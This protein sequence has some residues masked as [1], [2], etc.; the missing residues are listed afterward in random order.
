M[1]S[2]EEFRREH[3]DDL[4]E[5]RA[6]VPNAA[7][8]FDEITGAPKLIS[9]Q[10]GFL[11]GAAGQGRAVSGITATLFA[12]DPDQAA[13]A[14]LQEHNSLFGHGAEALDNAW[15]RRET[16]GPHNGLRT[17]VWQQ[18]AASIPIFEAVL[19]AHTTR[20]GELVNL[21][22]SFLPDPEQAAQQADLAAGRT[23][24]IP[25]IAARAAVK[26]AAEN[27][28]D[29][30]TEEQVVSVSGMNTGPELRET[31][32]A[33]G[34]LGEAAAALAWLPMNRQQLRLC[35]DVLLTSR[36]RG[37]MFRLLVDAQTGE[38]LVRHCLTDYLSDATY[39]VFT[40]DSPSPFSPGNST[41]VAAQP[42]FGS[43]VLV[44]LPALS[45]NAS[46]SGWINDNG[47]ET[48]GNNV[49]AH[50]DRNND[51]LAD[52][53]RPQGSPARTFDFAMDVSTQDPMS[54]SPAA[55]VQLFYLCNWM[56]DKLYD[57]GFTESAGNFQSNNFG[58]GGLSADAVQADAQDGGGFNNANF[59]TPPDGSPGRM[60]MYL[61]DGPAPDR[62]GDLDAEIVLHEYAHGLSNRRVGGGVGM[63]AL[64]S[65]GLGE[66]WSDFYALALL[67]ESGDDVNGC[68]ATGG[69]ATY[70]LS[71]L[72]QNYYFGIRRYPYSLDLSKNPL[73]FK[74]ID[75]AQASAHAGIPIS[76]II[77]NAAN[78]V[79]NMGEVWCV[80]LWET[81]A[82]LVNKYGWAGANAL[83]L[84]LVTDGMNLCPPNP[85][86][87]QA[88]DAILQADLV[89]SG[90]ENR[91][92]LWNGFA[93]R[94]LGQ[95]A[96]SPVSST[97]T[98]LIEA[99]DVPDTLQISPKLLA[100]SGPIGG[101]FTPNP[102][103]FI[104][105][106]WGADTLTWKL[107]NN[108]DWLAVAP[109]NGTLPAG[110]PA[111]IVTVAISGVTT[112]LSLGTSRATIWFTNQTSGIAQ[113]RVVILSV[114]GRTLFEDFEPGIHLSLWSGFGGTVGGTVIATNY[115]GSV[116]GLNS[117]WFGDADARSATTTAVNTTAGGS[118]SFYLRF[119]NGESAPWEIVELPSEGVV[120]ECSTNSG[121]SWTTLGSYGTAT[122]YNWTQV[123][124]TLPTGA[125]GL[126]TQ[127]RWRQL[128]HSGTCCD[129][130]AL[131]DIRIDAGPSS[132][133]V[134]NQP[135]SQTV[136]SGLNGSFTVSAQGSFPLIYQWRKD[137]AN[138]AN[139][140]RI[141]GAT[142]AT[143][144]ISSVLESDSGA[145]SVLV[146]NLYGSIISSNAMLLVTPLDHFEWSLISSPQA[147]GIPFSATL[148][149]KDAFNTTISN[150]SG[151]VNLSAVA[152]VAG[153]DVPLNLLPPA[154]TNFIGG[155]WSG[156]LTIQTPG[157][158]AV[159]RAED[160]NGHVG[161]S[162]IFDV[163]LQDDLSIT[164]TAS[165]D[166][167]AIGASLTYTITVANAG[168]SAATG[169]TVTNHLPAGA[170]FVSATVS[171]GTFTLTDGVVVCHLEALP[172]ATNAIVSIRVV[173]MVGGFITNNAVVSRAEAD[174]SLANNS[175][176]TV[177]FVQMPG[178][179][180]N[181]LD[182]LERNFGTTNVV[183]TVS[184]SSVP[185]LPVRLDYAT[186][187]GTAL[188]GSDYFSTNGT[189]TFLPGETNKVISVVVVGDNT[190]EPDETFLVTLTNP[191]NATLADGQGVGTILNDDVP[192]AVYLRSTVGP[193]WD[194]TVNE[195]AMN[196]VFGTNKW[197][198]LRYE[199][200][201]LAVL[202]SSGTTFIYMEGSDFNATELEAFLTS[203]GTA[204]QE[205]VS[206]GGCLFLNAAPNEDNG[207]DFGF[208]V[209]LTYSDGTTA[210]SA[211][212]PTHPIFRGPFIPVG[213]SWTGGSFGHATVSGSGLTSL[214]TN[215]ANGHI[216][217][218]EMTHGAGHVLFGGMTTDNF[219]APQPQASNLR[220]NILA[221][222]NT[223]SAYHFEWAAIASPQTLD[224]PFPVAIVARDL[225][226]A[227]MTNFNGVVSLNAL[228][229]SN[230]VIAITPISSGSFTN[231][232]WLGSI[233]AQ[234][235]AKSVVLMA[236][237]G[238]GH[239]G[240]SNP[241]DVIASNQPPAIAMQ[242]TNTAGYLGGT[243]AFQVLAV[244]AS[245]L[246]YQWR[247]NGANVPGATNATL[248]FNH[249]TRADAGSYSLVISN[250]QGLVSS[251]KA[252]LSIIEVA[253]W[254][255]GTNNNALNFNYGQA[256]VPANLTN[257][258]GLAG[259]LY[260]SLAVK[261]DGTVAAWGAGTNSPASGQSPDYGQS[262]V[263]PIGSV[264]AV[265]GGG[266]HTLALRSDGTVSAWGAGTNT[267]YSSPHYGQSLI[268]AS[269][270]KIVA[271]AAG[272]YH[273][274]ALRSDGRVLVWGLNNYGQ[275]NVPAAATSNVVAIASRGNHVLALRGD[276]LLVHWGELNSLPGTVSNIVSIAAGV[277]HCLALKSD[278]SIVSWGSQVSIPSGLSN[279]VEIAAGQEHN[280]A[281]RNDG[282]AVT[283][284]A[285]NSYGRF[286]IP[287]GLSNVIGVA[288]GGYH[289]LALLGDGFPAIKWQP[290]SRSALMGATTTFSVLGVGPQLRY[291]WQFNGSPI[292]DAT[293]EAYTLQGV[294]AKD[295]GNYRVILTN[296]FGA[297]T[298]SIASL[299]VVVPL[300][301]ALDS[302]NL[303][304]ST[305]GNA[306]WFG[307][308]RVNHD[309]VD[310]AQ[311]GITLNGQVSSLQTT[312]IG[313]G[314]VRF[315]WKVSSEEYF[316][317]L[318]CDL[319]GVEQAILSGESDWQSQTVAIGSGSHL[320]KWTYRK[321]ASVIAGLDAGWLDQVVVV[322]N[323]PVITLQPV[324][325]TNG[326]GGTIQ[327]TVEATGAPDLT[328]Q[329]FKGGT[330]L[331]GANASMLALPNLTRSD[332]GTYWAKVSNPGG[333]AFSS[334]AVLKIYVPQELV[335][336]GMGTAG[337]VL[338]SG[339]VDG[340]LMTPDDV[341]N[342][343]A[344]VSTNLLDWVTAPA[345][346]RLTNGQLL[347]EDHAAT[348]EPA[349]FYR[350]I[351]H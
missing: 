200:V 176:A 7:V 228:G 207:M 188:A 103:F 305:S 98:G 232:V 206:N 320:L 100:A 36:S 262:V 180:I 311:S 216:V 126:A 148:T 252:T 141:A 61:F 185:G 121:S 80:T 229:D 291:E 294:Q 3:Q 164:T 203:H 57:L 316:D 173:P 323:P 335:P 332:S 227:I 271:I 349:R 151:A 2:P 326:P 208:G 275:T 192:P 105:T 15:I 149:A 276:G 266:Y 161:T 342:F 159:V 220:A 231:G 301:T 129:H 315:W 257:V 146:T 62:D 10:D 219:H 317:Y 70:Q 139:G 233:T 30:F 255:A 4:A 25:A 24:A 221:Y 163:L 251:A 199:T 160:G 181:D 273:S 33:P 198:D 86:F 13:K 306:S 56:H 90:G 281:L 189:L 293:N 217:L 59:S 120:L 44:T 143:L 19:I 246:A 333:S 81:R 238:S 77:G 280:L 191:S 268:P 8:D 270:S 96:A 5:L 171:Q 135:A 260:H 114:A 89:N 261:A 34:L 94:G 169:V 32:S 20:G 313:P 351:E 344:Q 254:G 242:P 339:D 79:H 83:F 6:Q 298:S 41:P 303:I 152:A 76:P 296:A 29:T 297:S 144:N 309:G 290:I 314:S 295:A 222:L 288:C 137:G 95:S 350:I 167:V 125:L 113:S 304:W 75:P 197:Q 138:L 299:V 68:Y 324:S 165:P 235:A 172:A 18:Q 42:P 21:S 250:A 347:L 237:D 201:N 128:S 247:F 259:G 110:D 23:S 85:N 277:N 166:P 142:H 213:T 312:V 11:T 69:Y 97:T 31:F 224:A 46:P 328:Y 116:S 340:G 205:W 1:R 102:A 289:S 319:D 212:L 40:S 256:I 184:L 182:F 168:P 195:T 190:G 338:L 37:E 147:V 55:V 140:G 330:N 118:L 214:I 210:A 72:T 112:N 325:Q 99:F 243:G 264:V 244:A 307:Q 236:R 9:A 302:G 209:T 64:Q 124:L 345:A 12:A 249:L 49:D 300:A 45:T 218:S 186:S 156:L 48:L 292:L 258:M 226:N 74:D 88:R 127:F 321:D 272:D 154:A 239:A 119:G 346:L 327:F 67:S 286:A 285:T 106:N 178:I 225:N 92:E 117:L 343:E 322:T 334:N 123:T 341:P 26:Y 58:R 174:I 170:T 283:W 287:A 51:N 308:T 331:P 101:P 329:W 91:A 337:F 279:V 130:W 108:A 22:S 133:T 265:A 153:D 230:A 318:S 193:P 274:V 211:A 66:G 27:V 104:L 145:Y 14:F 278:G 52:L 134:L 39:R 150:F 17:V 183:F 35:W 84:Q 53:P 241:F 71:G 245:P 122:F 28:G 187:D 282:T 223:L 16:V 240:S 179:S 336:L 202:L 310:A 43:R 177:T 47:N 60:Q 267:L 248:V 175:S 284:G 73:T 107:A 82:K 78:E 157:P 115:G 38:I 109:S 87:I 253:A 194:S 50:T 196:R 131:D 136:K 111:A 348:N 263:P 65:G 132:P 215:V 158:N 155:I 204:I 269:A 63:S 93:R 54:Y 234:Q 162:R